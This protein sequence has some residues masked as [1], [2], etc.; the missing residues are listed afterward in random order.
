MIAK[1]LWRFA[2]WRA[3]RKFCRTCGDMKPA[4][5]CWVARMLAEYGLGDARCRR[6]PRSPDFTVAHTDDGAY[7]AFAGVWYRLAGGSR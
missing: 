7:V 2:V 3:K 1:L 4:C 6:L 5:D